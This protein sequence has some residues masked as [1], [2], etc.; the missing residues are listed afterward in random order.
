VAQTLQ[1]DDI[2]IM[3]KKCLFILLLASPLLAEEILYDPWGNPYCVQN[4][5]RDWYVDKDLKPVKVI[6]EEYWTARGI[7]TSP[8]DILAT[9]LNLQSG[10]L[11]EERLKKIIPLTPITSMDKF[12]KELGAVS[13]LNEKELTVEKLES[14]KKELDILI[15]E[16]KLTIK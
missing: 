3:I 6:N 5:L 12:Q 11:L 1:K 7:S 9:K 16:M 8:A 4:D 10:E 14:L 15:S 2:Q 13:A